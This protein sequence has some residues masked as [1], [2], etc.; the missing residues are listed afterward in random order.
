MAK[1]IVRAILVLVL[2]ASSGFTQLKKFNPAGLWRGVFLNNQTEV[3]FNFEIKDNGTVYLINAEERFESGTA[4]IVGDSL[5]IPLDQ[6]DNE[7]VFYTGDKKITGVLRKQDRSGTAI[8]VTAE[9]DK[10]YRFEEPAT[11]TSV[12]LSGTYDII[13][14]SPAG[15]EEK[16]VG[17]FTQNGGKL[18]ATF[19][20]ITGDSRYLDGIV[21]GNHFYLSSFIGSSPIYYTGTIGPDGK[22]SGESVYAKGSQQFTGVQNE[23]AALPDAFSLTTLKNGYSTLDFGFPDINGKTV[24]LHDEKYRNKV[25]IL[26]ITGTWCPN[27][28]DEASYL[29]PWYIQNKD[30]GVEAIAIHYERQTDPAFVS[31]VL[32]RFRHKYDIR[33]DQVIAG[34]A[35]KQK[36][37]ESL[38]ALNSFLA[39]PTLIF[40]DKK[41]KVAKIHTGYSGPATGKYYDQFKKEFNDEVDLLLKN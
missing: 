18:R 3:P 7:L 11:Q 16:A 40:I 28:V 21:S 17:L 12:D 26:S 19:L 8:P 25:V 36:V 35:D 4:K 37:A 20:R 41:G 30:R 6:F 23:N 5:F 14:K 24:S 9:R 34:V 27:C 1:T 33:Y 39:F 32:N 2:A 38:P 29:A 13:F 31:K 10:K 15:T 22:L